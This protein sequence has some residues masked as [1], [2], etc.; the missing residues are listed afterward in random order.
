MLGI[1]QDVLVA[2]AAVAAVAWLVRRR[3]KKKQSCDDC[4]L[5]EAVAKAGEPTRPDRA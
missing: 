2:A 4:A 1:W 3:L 5:A